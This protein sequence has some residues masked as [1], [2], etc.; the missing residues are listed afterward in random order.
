MPLRFPDAGIRLEDTFLKLKDHPELLEPLPPKSSSFAE[1]DLGGPMRRSRAVT[2]TAGEQ[3]QSMQLQSEMIAEGGSIL[4][5][6]GGSVMGGLDESVAMGGVD[7]TDPTGAA[8]GLGGMLEA[9]AAGLAMMR[10]KL[11]LAEQQLEQNRRAEAEAAAGHESAA[12]DGSHPGTLEWGG[13]ALSGPGLVEEEERA[14]ERQRREL[15]RRQRAFALKCQLAGRSVELVAA[16]HS[17]AAAAIDPGMTE[18]ADFLGGRTELPVSPRDR[19]QE[20]EEDDYEALGLEPQQMVVVGES[21]ALRGSASVTMAASA[22]GNSSPSWGS[23]RPRRTASP[24]QTMSRPRSS[25]P[26][27][28]LPAS[29]ARRSAGVTMSVASL[30][31]EA[32]APGDAGEDGQAV[33][34]G[35]V[36]NAMMSAAAQRASAEE[37]RQQVVQSPPP[38]SPAMASIIADHVVTADPHR[39]LTRLEKARQQASARIMLGAEP[40]SDNDSRNRSPSPP[41]T[42]SA[43]V[44]AGAPAASMPT[45]FRQPRTASEL[46]FRPPPPPLEQLSTRLEA[47]VEEEQP[48]YDQEE[49][50][51]ARVKSVTSRVRDSLGVNQLPG[52][53][54]AYP[55]TSHQLAAMDTDRNGKVSRGEFAQ[56]PRSVQSTMA[57]AEYVGGKSH[58][59]PSLL[60]IPS[61]RPW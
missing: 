43:R 16:P 41:R 7:P 6:P 30:L 59:V 11:A 4:A 45:A 27:A 14:L 17:V 38:P 52:Y 34:G 54:A 49:D 5:A 61:T 3:S 39:K 23:R 29:V 9:Q 31:P 12:G 24:P 10:D 22:V 51:D 21:G 18:L 28:K 13:V 26:A 57:Y 53:G 50:E 40:P 56:H 60:L 32:A 55:S 15:R 36:R 58:L 25:N 47:A 2:V 19:Q 20:P 35:G 42:I 33:G 37:S 8:Q 48:D 1:K 46:D 44:A